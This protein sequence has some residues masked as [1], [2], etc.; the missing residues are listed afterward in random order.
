M[1]PYLHSA[2]RF[3]LL[4]VQRINS[5]NVK[6]AFFINV[7]VK[8]LIYVVDLNWQLFYVYHYIAAQSRKREL[9]LF[10]DSAYRTYETCFT[11]LML[12]GL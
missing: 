1:E 11:F 2:I 12:D 4:Y 7:T 8:L 5:Y 3:T 6:D 9:F 10:M